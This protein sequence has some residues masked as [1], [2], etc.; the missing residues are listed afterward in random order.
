MEYK[1]AD[2]RNPFMGL[3]NKVCRSPAY[4]CRLHQVWLSEQDVK[5]KK[6]L[7]K[8]D[9]RMISTRKCGELEKKDKKSA[10]RGRKRHEQK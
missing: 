7:E 4:W 5:R 10:A 8:P 3:N 1:R 2:N 9:M 6:C